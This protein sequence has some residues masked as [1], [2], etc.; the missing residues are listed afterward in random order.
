VVSSSALLRNIYPSGGLFTENILLRLRDNPEQLEIGRIRTFVEKDIEE[1][2]R[3]FKEKRR[4][5]FE[6][7]VQKWDE[8]SP[9]IEKWALD[10]LIQ[11]WLVPFF[12][13]FDHELEKFELKKENIDEDSPLKDFSITHQSE[14]HRNPFFHC[15][16]LQEDFDSRIDSNPIRKSHHEVCQQFLNLNPEIKWLF[17]SNGRILRVLTKYY[18]SYSKGFLEFDLENIFANR[19]YIEFNV[20]YSIIHSSRYIRETAEELRLIE[21]F[22]EESTKEGVKVGDSLRDNVHEALELL[23]NGLIQQNYDFFD[24]IKSG[25]VDLQEY[26]AE[27]LRIIYRIIFILYAEQRNMLPGAGTL[28]FEQFSLSSLRML[29][30]HPIKADKSW[31]L[32]NKLFITFDLVRDGN[33]FLEVPCYNGALFKDQN[34]QIILE[35]N[36]KLSNDLF[37]NIIRLLTMSVNYNMRQRINF[38]E[39]RE[40][41]IGAIYESLL[42]YKPSIALNSEFQLIPQTIERKS[43]G[44]YYTPKELIDILIRTTLQ[45]LVEKRLKEIESPKEREFAILDLKIC[46]PACGGGTFLLAALDFLGKILAQVRTEVASPPEDDLRAAR[47]DI[48]Q[49]CIYGVDKNPL[50]VEL[51][52]ISLWLRAC[53]RDK[54]LNFLDNHIK[55]GN[56]L[57][58]LGKKKEISSINPG[59]FIALNGNKATGIPPESR[60]LQNTARGEIRKENR[61]QQTKGKVT[62]ITAFFTEEKTADICSVEFQKL[63]ELPE[64]TPS[65]IIEK[66]TQYQKLLS[67]PE[68][69]QSLH[70][71]DIWTSTFFWPLEGTSLGKIPSYVLIDELRKNLNRDV[72]TK[73]LQKIK[74]IAVDNQFFHWFIEFPEVFSSEQGGFDCILTNPPWEGLR[75]MENE[76]FAGINNEI[77]SASNQSKRRKLIKELSK[78][79]IVLF[80]KYKKAWKNFQRTNHFL[81][82]SH[83]FDLS[84]KGTMNTYGLFTERCYNLISSKGYLGIIIP[85]GIITNYFMSDLF[86]YLAQNNAILSLFDFENKNKL[87]DMDPSKKFCLLTIGGRKLTQQFIPMSFNALNPE[88]IQ[89]PLSFIFENRNNIETRYEKLSNDHRLIILDRGDFEL[90]NPNTFTCPI[91]SSK[92]EYLL[93]KKIYQNNL[94]FHKKKTPLISSL[95]IHRMFHMSDDSEHFK[96]KKEFN[97]L[98]SKNSLILHKDDQL[99]YPLYESKLFWIYDHRFASFKGCNDDEI[100]NGNPRKYPDFKSNPDYVIEPRFWISKNLFDKK[101]AKYN[102]NK[103]W[104]LAVRYISNIANQRTCIATI[105]PDYPSGNSLHLIY[106]ISALDALFLLSMMSSFIFDYIARQKMSGTNLKAYI[107]KQLPVIEHNKWKKYRDIIIP[108]II[109]LIYTSHEL[110]DFAK[111]C[112]FSRTPFEW[113]DSRR[114][115]IKAEL[116]AIIA[117]LY[118]VNKT[119]LKY[120]IDTF[121]AL[122]NKEIEI[123]DE[124]KSKNLILKFF[125]KYSGLFK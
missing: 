37:L 63:I 21:E 114:F 100:K 119:E 30:E 84:S 3:K 43:T 50:A 1:E 60:K 115:Q 99:Y 78:K 72:N 101:K 125:D 120:I 93:A 109:E 117:H 40:E 92:Y 23:G 52:K 18:H 9:N 24:K 32:W 55:L 108:K 87:F 65:L 47:R 29:A 58:G 106:G 74:S 48:L 73:F 89:D 81:K 56:S 111:E 44:S 4:D 36:L 68:Y 95:E 69:Q 33:E 12:T 102:W 94:I 49:H 2:R 86:G 61:M 97:E 51:A 38:R 6:W 54:P 88:E 57:I 122:K 77:L 35:N 75:F 80:E 90:F 64:D 19:D 107:L 53:V 11:K 116:N 71:A 70:E 96:T 79:N 15:V 104:F 124:F 13:Q 85:T 103:K 25:E 5:V 113:N 8:I 67:Y 31:D 121:T 123:F 83:L 98:N 112:G 27:L 14:D 82:N 59:A 76:F 34:L 41:E 110:T 42:D 22:Q 62:R 10:E 20:L 91:F 16:P 28:Y 118:G 46:D 26:Y 17:L 66:E 39:I 45:P 7:C 105:I